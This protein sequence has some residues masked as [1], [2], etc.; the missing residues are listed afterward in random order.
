[1]QDILHTK[2]QI[3]LREKSVRGMW[4]WI[5]L[6]VS[7]IIGFVLY[8]CIVVGAYA[9]YEIERMQTENISQEAEES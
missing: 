6:G 9:D 3:L 4:I 5:G 2:L 8:C 1:M 7:L